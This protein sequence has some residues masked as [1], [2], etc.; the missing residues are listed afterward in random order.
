[1]PELIIKHAQSDFISDRFLWETKDNR[2]TDIA[3]TIFITDKQILEIYIERILRDW[4]KG[5][6]YAVFNNRNM[7]STSFNTNLIAHLSTSV[8]T[9][10]SNSCSTMSKCP[11]WQ[12]INK[13][14]VPS[15]LHLFTY[16]LIS[17]CRITFIYCLP[18]RTFRH[19]TTT[20]R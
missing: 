9:F 20:I 19:C 16:V 6:V 5:K 18:G 14:D 13:G 10:L 3:Y 11:F 17:P 4:S 15:S 7:K 1:M 2:T 8:L 12:A